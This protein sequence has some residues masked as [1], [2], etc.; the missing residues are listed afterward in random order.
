MVH[1]S[2]FD[3]KVAILSKIAGEGLEYVQPW[4]RCDYHQQLPGAQKLS[5]GL[6]F[7]WNKNYTMSEEM[8][9]PTEILNSW[10]GYRLHPTKGR[11]YDFLNDV[12]RIDANTPTFIFD[13]KWYPKP[14]C[15]CQC[16]ISFTS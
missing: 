14:L 2:K 9:S 8:I 11:I 12:C 15:V 10:L 7:D 6:L 4:R 3:G 5:R 1:V 16:K 13:G